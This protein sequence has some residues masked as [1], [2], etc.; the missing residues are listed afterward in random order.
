MRGSD[1]P[2]T[3]PVVD[4]RQAAAGENQR[5][6][7]WQTRR[8]PAT[9]SYG[10]TARTVRAMFAGPQRA[11]RGKPRDAKARGLSRENGMAARPPDTLHP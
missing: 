3:V 9:Q 10:T 11:N 8:N 7:L 2:G 5:L 1:P 4:A 6:A